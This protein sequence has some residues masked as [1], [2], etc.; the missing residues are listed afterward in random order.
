MKKG[1]RMGQLRNECCGMLTHKK[2]QSGFDN[3]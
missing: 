1:R 3:E 2:A